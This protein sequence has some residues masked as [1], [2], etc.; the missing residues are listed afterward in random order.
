MN[1]HGVSAWALMVVMV[2]QGMGA[3]LDQSMIFSDA[4]CIPKKA[5]F[6]MTVALCRSAPAEGISGKGL[7][8]HEPPVSPMGGG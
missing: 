1:T 7:G 8:S 2:G 5:G 3:E 6:G 4:V